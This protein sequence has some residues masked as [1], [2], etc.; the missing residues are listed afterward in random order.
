MAITDDLFEA[1]D[2]IVTARLSTL[3]YDK[4]IS[5]T[6][7][8][9]SNAAKGIYE[10]TSQAS[11]FE[12]FGPPNEYSLNDQVYVVI[13]E[14]DF[15][16]DKFITGKVYIKQIPTATIQ[17][18]TIYPFNDIV[19][20]QKD[21]YVSTN[22]QDKETLLM[23]N[24]K[25]SITEIPIIEFEEPISG[26]DVLGIKFSV[27]AD[28]QKEMISGNYGVYITFKGYKK[29]SLSL[30]QEEALNKQET[31][32]EN[33][34][35]SILA[36]KNMLVPDIYNTLGECNQNGAFDISNYVITQISLNLWQDDNFKDA[37]G[38]L[39]LPKA[40]KFNN[41]GL[42]LGYFKN[43]FTDNKKIVLDTL[44]GFLYSSIYNNKTLKLKYLSYSSQD[45]LEEY[46][47]FPAVVT[48]A[49]WKNDD[50]TTIENNIFQ[51]NFNN[52]KKE[53]TCQY[54]LTDDNNKVFKSNILTFKNSVYLEDE[55]IVNYSNNNNARIERNFKKII[56]ALKTIDDTINIELE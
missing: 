4:T 16:K 1:I 43:G 5:C 52:N 2:T 48:K 17:S 47:N 22:Y 38:E 9:I 21:N 18:Q 34:E 32:G 29:N 11:T 23:I 50:T 36:D 19:Y 39:I 42:Y 10:V 44:D 6:V 55:N 30:S 27:S 40:I 14:N 25:I 33:K 54:I 3:E 37:S 28:I 41:F 20:N 46:E 15:D 7:S 45:G 49:I 56:A 35:F 8:N 12:A 53:E 26:Y 51:I 31:F 13:P 24:N